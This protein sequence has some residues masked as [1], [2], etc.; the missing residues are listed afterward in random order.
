MAKPRKSKNET[1]YSTNDVLALM[2]EA[3]AKA[4]QEEYQVFALLM[5]LRE[6][7]SHQGISMRAVAKKAG[8]S[9]SHLSR[10]F[11]PG[12]ENSVK[13]LTLRR[14]ASAVGVR[15]RLW[16]QGPGAGS[17]TIP[18]GPQ[19]AAM[20]TRCPPAPYAPTDECTVKLAR[21]QYERLCSLAASQGVAVDVLVA[22]LLPSPLKNS[23]SSK[24]QRESSKTAS[25]R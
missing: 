21:T 25:P 16:Y 23:S 11:S 13:W 10:V 14:I 22:A 20:A 6:E 1:T 18:A 12:Y 7:M 9:A 19:T 17:Y 3:G 2:D 5:R 8:T 4:S 15:L 24:H